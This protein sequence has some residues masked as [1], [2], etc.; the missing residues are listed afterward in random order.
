M[1]F[2]NFSLR[3]AVYPGIFLP[4]FDLM[5]MKFKTYLVCKWRFIQFFPVH[6]K[7]ISDNL[8]F[9]KHV[10]ATHGDLSD[11][12]VTSLQG[13]VTFTTVN[14]CDHKHHIL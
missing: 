9:I 7:V 4:E 6:S 1:N 11:P 5:K 13:R 8:R 14:S 12:K 3:W 2:L 10:K